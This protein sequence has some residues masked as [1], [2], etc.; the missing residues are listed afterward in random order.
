MCESL[1]TKNKFNLT[2]EES[3]MRHRSIALTARASLVGACALIGT[4]SGCAHAAADAPP[5][6][7]SP[8]RKSFAGIWLASGYTCP[9]GSA[10]AE[11]QI[12]IAEDG[13]TL[14]ATKV[15]GDHCI[16]AGEITWRGVALGGFSPGR[17]FP[18]QVQVGT[19]G[20]PRHF[21]DISLTVHDADR[22]VLNWSTWTV[23]YRRMP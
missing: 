9:D 19:P 4:L 11:E 3:R 18:V 12:S 13:E 20:G 5:A 8:Q 2:F 7:T 6:T 16:P 15:T 14:T 23:R 10:P 1:A 22:F 17:S 21:I